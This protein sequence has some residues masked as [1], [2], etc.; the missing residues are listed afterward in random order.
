MVRPLLT[1][2]QLDNNGTKRAIVGE[3]KRTLEELSRG[4]PAQLLVDLVQSGWGKQ[5]RQV[6][7]IVCTSLLT[8]QCVHITSTACTS[9]QI[10]PLCPITPH[11]HI[12]C[13]HHFTSPY[14]MHITLLRAHITPDHHFACISSH[15][16]HTSPLSSLTTLL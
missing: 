14:C 15:C 6:S 7:H 4:D 2:T 11:H 1:Y 3:A 13:P 10:P 9:L 5:A 16:R 12:A 8:S